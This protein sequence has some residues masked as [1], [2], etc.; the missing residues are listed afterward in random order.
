VIIF[1]FAATKC[2]FLGVIQRQSIKYTA[3]NF[4]GTFLGFLSVIFIY[5]L[6]QLL[7]GTFQAIYGY[8][9]LLV[10][11]LSFGIQSA[12]IKFYPEMVKQNK[13]SR[14]LVFTLI[15]TTIS[16]MASTIILLCVY[17]FM[18][19]WL[20]GIFPNFK[21]VDE[22]LLY[23]FLLS[24]LITFTSIFH[25]HAVAKFR[26]VIPDLL[27]T[28]GLKLFLPLLILLVY[29]GFWPRPW[30][31]YAILVYFSIVCLALFYYLNMLGAN[32][33]KPDL[34][35]LDKS[36][37]KEFKSFMGFATLNGLGASLALRLDIAMITAM[38]S[39]EAVAIYGIIMTISNVME[40]P[41]KALNQISSPVIST[42]WTNGNHENIQDVYQKSSVYGLIG[43]LFLFLLLYFIWP[44]IIQLMSG[45]N[46][47]D[48][49]TV[50]MVFSFLSIARIID[51]VTGVNSIIIS[52]SKDYKF[53]MYFLLV[54]GGLNFI[55]N[56]LLLPKYGIIGAAIA[57]AISYVI[58]NVIKYVFVQVRFGFRLHF[59]SHIL[60]IASGL[61]CFVVLSLVNT[62]FHPIVNLCLKSIIIATIYGLLMYFLNPG[63]EIRQIVYENLNKLPFI[64]RIRS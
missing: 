57:T 25:Y 8:A 45:K 46:K 27:V 21:V 58:F 10:P 47:F 23:I 54:L 31:I 41:A 38:I 11:F 17:F 44:D 24:Y 15:L 32:R 42:S 35:L 60:I 28:L 13:A 59:R 2:N 22:N 18:R 9:V 52:Y 62:T 12:I 51:L 6:D 19:S 36:Q 37:F 4:I 39:L 50:L 20:A 40:I 64:R 26:I 48:L 30:F 43:G 34:A 49:H 63:G 55:L 29:F 1:S 14:F 7:Y 33:W 3:I 61:F 53:H 56:F 16:V 5:N